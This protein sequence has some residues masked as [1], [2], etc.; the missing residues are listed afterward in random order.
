LDLAR[1]PVQQADPDPA[2]DA[3]LLDRGG[4]LLQELTPVPVGVDAA[5]PSKTSIS[6]SDRW[7]GVGMGEQLRA[8]ARAMTPG[9]LQLQEAVA[10]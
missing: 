4:D 6:S 9:A 10:D 7:S 5:N 2:P 8:G 1:H 3:G